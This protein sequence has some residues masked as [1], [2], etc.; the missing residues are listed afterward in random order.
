MKLQVVLKL[1]L[2]FLFSDRFEVT[3]ILKNVTNGQLGSYFEDRLCSTLNRI[4]SYVTC[5]LRNGKHNC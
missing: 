5:Q 2:F 1:Q 3:T 4:I